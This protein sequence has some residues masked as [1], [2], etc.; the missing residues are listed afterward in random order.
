M[1]AKLTLK[2]Y[3]LPPGEGRGEEVTAAAVKSDIP[4]LLNLRQIYKF[5]IGFFN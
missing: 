5:R 3:P 4:T 1:F 2:N